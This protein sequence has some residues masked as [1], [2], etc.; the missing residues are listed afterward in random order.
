MNH[1]L[2]LLEDLIQKNHIAQ[3]QPINSVLDTYQQNPARYVKSLA[4]LRGPGCSRPLWPA[5]SAA[6]WTAATGDGHVGP[7]LSG[8]CP[9]VPS[10]GQDCTIP[11]RSVG[12]LYFCHSILNRICIK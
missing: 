12:D 5:E 6:L 4:F 1:K 7:G 2:R 8:C 3:L 9:M 10:G 11:P